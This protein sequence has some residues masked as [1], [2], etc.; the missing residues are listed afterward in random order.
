MAA[1]G[2]AAR[3][4]S[5]GADGFFCQPDAVNRVSVLSGPSQTSEGPIGGRSLAVGPR[6]SR[7]EPLDAIVC[8]RSLLL[9]LLRLVAS[10]G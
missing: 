6:L 7:R 1:G 9:S 8:L 4:L 5:S 3:L 2:S 10:T